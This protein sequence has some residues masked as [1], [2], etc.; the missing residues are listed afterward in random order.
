MKEAG[1]ELNLEGQLAGRQRVFQMGWINRNTGI[2]AGRKMR[3]TLLA[4]HVRS[5]S[6]V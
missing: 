6:K 4:P 2:K 3:L 5:Q 1:P